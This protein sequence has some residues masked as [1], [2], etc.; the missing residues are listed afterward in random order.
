D[1]SVLRPLGDDD[2]RAQVRALIADGVRSIA[3]VFLHSHAEPAHERRAAQL[4]REV[5]PDLAVSVSHAVAPELR[6]YERTSTTVANAYVL[7]L[8]GTYLRDLVAR[9]VALGLDAPLFLMLSDG[10]TTGADVAAELPIRI[11]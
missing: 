7:P 9:L 2:V 3:I 11:L 4:V 1:G 5:A 8:V 10:G 6:E